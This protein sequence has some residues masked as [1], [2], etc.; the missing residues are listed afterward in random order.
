MKWSERIILSKHISFLSLIVCRQSIRS[1]G[2]RRPAALCTLWWQ[3][4]WTLSTPSR[5]RR[6]RARYWPIQCPNLLLFIRTLSRH[7]S[8]PQR[9]F[10][11]GDRVWRKIQSELFQALHLVRQ[12]L[13]VTPG[14][15]AVVPAGEVQRGGAEGAVIQSVLQPASNPP[16]GV[17]QGGDGA[18]ESGD[19]IKF[20][21]FLLLLM[22][23][24]TYILPALNQH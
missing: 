9:N 18:P 3:K 24:N 2:G 6:S 8:S 4:H 7:V 21:H 12:F 23:T 19:Y 14:L 11:I 22:N 15:A 20:D 17:G 1:L 13:S 16:D 10:V 5:C